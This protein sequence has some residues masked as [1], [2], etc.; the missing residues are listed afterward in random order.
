IW[1]HQVQAM[2]ATGHAQSGKN[3]ELRT[4]LLQLARLLCMPVH[5]VFVFDGPARPA[6]KWGKCVVPTDHWMVNTMKGFII[7]FGFDWWMAPGET[8]AELAY[9]NQL[10]FIDGV[11]TDNSDALLIGARTVIQTYNAKAKEFLVIH[12]DSIYNHPNVQLLRKDMLLIALLLGGWPRVAHG[13]ARYRSGQQLSDAIRAHGLHS[14]KFMEFLRGWQ[15]AMQRALRTDDKKLLGRRYPALTT[16][17]PETFPDIDIIDWYRNPATSSH[18]ELDLN[19]PQPPNMV[20]LGLLCEHYFSWG[21]RSGIV[22][23]F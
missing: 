10:G 8:E 13:L 18:D 2:F 14:K 3:P 20:Q 6:R 23:H 9:L 4:L 11:M 21:T 17:I 22:K 16:Q 12:A 5:V 19:N 7:V 15:A 1:F